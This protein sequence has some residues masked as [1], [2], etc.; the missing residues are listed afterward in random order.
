MKT[1]YSA[2]KVFH[3]R[4]ILD[5]IEKGEIDAPLYI[6][7]KPTNICNHHCRYCTYGSGNTNQKTENRDLISYTDMIPRQKML[8]IIDD[9]GD[10]AVKAV[11]FSG[12]GEPL[13][14][15]YI[16][17]TVKRIKE[18]NIELSLIS[19]GQLLHGEI[20]ELFYDAKNMQIYEE[21]LLQILIL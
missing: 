20:A 3:H 5:S 16:V 15:P 13:T 11:T 9:R 10:M 1:S 21:Y 6:R 12:G 8:E 19:N 14:Y 17:E 4:E 7:I 18:K 2:I